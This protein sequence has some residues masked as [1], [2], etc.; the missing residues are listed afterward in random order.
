MLRL[1]PRCLAAPAPSNATGHLRE[2]APAP[3]DPRHY[4]GQ[5]S[6]CGVFHGRTLNIAPSSTNDFAE[7]IPPWRARVALEWLKRVLAD[8]TQA[9]VR[10]T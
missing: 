9:K 7:P 6:I 1:R 4:P 5:R 3:K 2:V 8:T 10:V